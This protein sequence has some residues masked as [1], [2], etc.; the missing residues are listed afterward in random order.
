MIRAVICAVLLFQ[1]E[2]L[3]RT[4]ALVGGQSIT[5]S[6]ARAAIALGLVATDRSADPIPGVVG[7][8][9]DRELVLREVQ[10]YSPPAPAESAVTAKLEE[11]HQRFSSAAALA[12]VLDRFGFAE[13]R[14]VAWVRDDLRTQAYLAQ[15]FASASTP[16][17]AEIVTAY[18]GAR[19]E[20]DS[21]NL[22]FEQ[23]MPV[24]RERMTAS[25][26]DEL[27]A[28]W[29]SDLRRRTEVVILPK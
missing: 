2:L 16:T 24:L 7:R 5:L 26:R 25:R 4:L 27:I 17:D 8:L 22:T 28:D 14:L 13:T 11:I 15:R 12:A 21:R 1:P 9:V 18:N 23:A 20:F 29:L 19:A 10:R 6:D 3:D